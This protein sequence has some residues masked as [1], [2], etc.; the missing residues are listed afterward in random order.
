MGGSAQSLER[1]SSGDEL[2]ELRSRIGAARKLAPPAQGFC[3]KA[4]VEG[5]EPV[6]GTIA[7]PSPST[8]HRF[9]GALPSLPALG[10]FIDLRDKTP[11]AEATGAS[12][13]W[14]SSASTTADRCTILAR[15]H[16]L[17]HRA[18]RAVR[19]LSKDCRRSRRTSPAR[20]GWGRATATG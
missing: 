15:A 12:Q 1:G 14:R 11:G 8:E 3:R 7:R 16:A 6:H 13:P 4:D 2:R 17:P 5:P 10:C 18:W 19:M 9:R 20:A